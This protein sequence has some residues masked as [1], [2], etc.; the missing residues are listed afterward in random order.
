MRAGQS[1]L[2]HVVRRHRTIARRLIVEGGG[3]ARPQLHG[4]HQPVG[5]AA[6]Y[7]RVKHAA[8]RTDPLRA[9]GRDRARVAEGIAVIVLARQ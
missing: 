7:F 1:N 5:A 4:V 2:R 9:A 3:L 8:P 6:Q